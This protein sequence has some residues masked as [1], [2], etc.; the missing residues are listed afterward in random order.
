VK[1]KEHELR[2]DPPLGLARNN[3]AA[4]LSASPFQG[5]ASQLLERGSALV[6]ACEPKVPRG[7]KCTSGLRKNT[8]PASWDVR[9]QQNAGEERWMCCV[10][11]DGTQ[12]ARIPYCLHKARFLL[13]HRCFWINCVL[14]PMQRRCRRTEVAAVV[15][16]FLNLG[17]RTHRPSYEQH[18]S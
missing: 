18:Y 8:Q 14:K 7:A 1:N 12:E 16:L 6:I 2:A 9:R 4:T 3:A 10:V 15:Y 17:G 5:G 11:E 13:W